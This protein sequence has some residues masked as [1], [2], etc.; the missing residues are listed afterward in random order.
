MDRSTGFSAFWP[1]LGLIVFYRPLLIYLI[2][3]DYILPSNRAQAELGN[4][5]RFPGMKLLELGTR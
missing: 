5:K 2:A 3:G 4:Q 1:S